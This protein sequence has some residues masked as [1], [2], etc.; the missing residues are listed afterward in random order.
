MA[1]GKQTLY[2]NYSTIGGSY[3]TAVGYQAGYSTNMSGSNVFLGYQAGYSETGSNKLYISNNNGSS[4]AALIYGE[5]NAMA[6]SQVLAV[7]AGTVKFPNVG[8]TGSG[9]NVYMDANGQIFKQTSSLRYK[10]DVQPLVEDW[11]KILQAQPKSFKFI[12]SGAEGTGYIA[13]EFDALGITDLVEYDDKGRPDNIN[14]Q[15]IPLWLLEVAKQQQVDINALKSRLGISVDNVQI[16]QA[17]TVGSGSVL[18]V[19]DQSIQSALA[20]MGV[21]LTSGVMALKQVLVDNLTAQTADISQINI[22]KMQIVDQANGEVYC[23]WI[24]NG[25]WQK[26]K[27]E[28]ADVSIVTV[29]TVAATPVALASPTTEEIQVAAQAAQQAAQQAKNSADEANHSN[30]SAK[31]A[32]DQAQ[33]VV[34]EQAQTLAEPE[35]LNISSVAPISDINVEYGTELSSANL[36]TTVTA[37]LSDDT[38]ESATI[39][40]DGGTPAYDANTAGTYVFLGTLSFSSSITNTDNIT[41]SASVVVAEIVEEVPVEEEV[42]APE[43]TVGDLIDELTSTLLNGTWNFIKWIFGSS[44]E[45]VSSVPIIQKSGASLSQAFSWVSF[46]PITKLFGG[47]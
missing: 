5:F 43:S 32:A 16:N 26:T 8:T 20:N 24:A 33:Q 13:E 19:F 14:Y 41:A 36:P 12:D 31:Q 18:G 30:N 34:A 15:K 46:D 38:T 9:A 35:V 10:T 4:T 6:S 29:Q 3:N 7:N 42:I 45:A 22:Q 44:A 2:G 21:T 40:W 47:K 17:G 27:G 39:T 25:E 28:C 11:S 37:T 23:T 1:I